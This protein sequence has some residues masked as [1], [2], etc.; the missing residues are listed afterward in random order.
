M[1]KQLLVSVV[2]CMCAFV[3]AQA[4]VIRQNDVFW[5]G[6]MRYVVSI[7]DKGIY[8]N[9]KDSEG[10]NAVIK[11]QKVG[12]TPGEYKLIKA[13]TNA[14]APYGC[15]FGSRVHY[16]NQSG[17]KF[18]EFYPE[19]HSVGQVLVLTTDKLSDLAK[20]QRFMENEQ[21]PVNVVSSWVMNQKFLSQIHP[22]VLQKMINKVQKKEKKNII[23]RVNLDMMAYAQA[24]G[25]F[26]TDGEMGSSEDQII[27]VSNEYEFISALGSNR[28]VILKPGTV[29][30]LTKV[31]REDGFFSYDGR[32]VKEDYHA[33]RK[34]TEQAIVA[35]ERNDGRQL[36][37]INVDNLTIRGSGDCY[38]VVE[39]RYANVLNF[40]KCSLVTIENLTI[41]HTEEGYCEGG[42]LLFEDSEGI[43]VKGC[44]LYGCGTYGLETRAVRDLTFEKTTIR[45]CSYG[46]MEVHDTHNLLFDNCQF[47]RCREF[48]LVNVDGDCENVR[49]DSCRWEDNKGKLFHLGAVVKMA[50]CEIRHPSAYE[51][52]DTDMVI[53]EGI[54][55]VIER[56]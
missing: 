39:P 49:F 36:E 56:Y 10:D 40:Y 18:L 48:T 35:C 45:D 51:I 53:M 41:G 13:H 9:G 32:Y 52:G 43:D 26:A 14:V 54:S 55:N 17:M 12:K 2:M 34:G 25:L 5:D 27:E 23:E 7:V 21:N 30:N 46:I 4:Q 47:L 42:V 1:R 37:L 31:L 44:D 15:L 19:E 38:I 16:V 28:T 24:V 6:Q 22:E 11:L 29:L 33:L 8:L 3:E 20:Q 50:G